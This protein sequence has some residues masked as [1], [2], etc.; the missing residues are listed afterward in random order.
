MSSDHRDE[1]P[2]AGP[3]APL[4]NPGRRRF[5]Q[6]GLGASAVLGVL[7]AKPVL[8]SADSIYHCTVSGHVSG[9]MSRVETVCSELGDSPGDWLLKESGWNPTAIF[10]VL[11][12]NGKYFYWTNNGNNKALTTSKTNF[13][14][15]MKDMLESQRTDQP[16]ALGTAA[17]ANLLNAKQ[18]FQSPSARGFPLTEERVKSMFKAVY[19]TGG[20][21]KAVSGANSVDWGRD[22]VTRYFQSLYDPSV[23]F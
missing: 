7:H 16:F 20:V 18:E 9:N 13:P 3:G 14:A 22:K 23:P 8:A 21:Y 12:D 17:A 1:T 2:T 11:F 15:T 4:A 10:N 5:A 6:A 19:A